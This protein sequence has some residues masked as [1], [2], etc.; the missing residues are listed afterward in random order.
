MNQEIE[1][2]E[3]HAPRPPYIHACTPDQD[4]GVLELPVWYVSRVHRCIH[5]CMCVAQ[6]AVSH[7][8]FGGRA[9]RPG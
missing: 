8:S 7:R 1:C 5:A 4:S 2:K 3:S 9:G 6:L